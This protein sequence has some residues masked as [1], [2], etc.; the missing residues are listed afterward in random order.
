MVSMVSPD[1]EIYG[2]LRPSELGQARCQLSPVRKH[3][4][5]FAC[6]DAMCFK[7]DA[8]QVSSHTV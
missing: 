8:N 5:P 2:R 4:L 6:L 7:R 1:L 3:R